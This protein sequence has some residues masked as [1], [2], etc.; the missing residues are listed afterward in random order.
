MWALCGRGRRGKGQGTLWSP[1]WSRSRAFDAIDVEC[2]DSCV[3]IASLNCMVV[4]R[5]VQCPGCGN[6][7]NLRVA[8]TLTHQNQSQCSVIVCAPQS[9]ARSSHQS[10]FS[11]A[12]IVGV[13]F[14]SLSAAAGCV[15]PKHV[16]AHSLH[17]FEAAARAPWPLLSGA[18]V[19]WLRAWRR[20]ALARRGGLGA[21]VR[22]GRSGARG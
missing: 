16:F 20:A 17:Q 11:Q 2:S 4:L 13:W 19:P 8:E 22:E 6:A 9:Q 10:V 15:L 12:S 5:R 1:Q 3:S 14:L 7:Q 21:I 18:R